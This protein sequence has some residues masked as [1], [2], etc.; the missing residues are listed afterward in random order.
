MDSCAETYQLTERNSLPSI[1]DFDTGWTFVGTRSAR[2]SS[3][4]SSGGVTDSSLPSSDL[5]S[6]SSLHADLDLALD[7]SG[8]VPTTAEGKPGK[9]SNEE[10]PLG[11]AGDAAACG[12]ASPPSRKEE[13][14][15]H[16]SQRERCRIPAL[17]LP[18]TCLGLDFAKNQPPPSEAGGTRTHTKLPTRPQSQVTQPSMSGGALHAANASS[19]SGPASS[20]WKWALK[21]SL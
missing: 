5:R 13:E 6:R 8:P 14:R 16:R 11:A 9:P 1:V 18:E 3:A 21:M 10:D 19:G 17:E 7:I 12:S 2:D 20:Q 15:P 4:T